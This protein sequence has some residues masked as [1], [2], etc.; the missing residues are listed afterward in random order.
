MLPHIHH[1]SFHQKFFQ[2]SDIGWPQQPP[3]ER[4]SDICKTSDFLCSI[5]QNGTNIDH[6]SSRDDQTIRISKYFD[7]MRLLR[8]LRPSRL[9][10][11]LRSSRLQR[12]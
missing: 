6:L 10:R 8:S 4:V 3:T 11:S 9:L 7:E 5:L 12:V 1:L 2:K